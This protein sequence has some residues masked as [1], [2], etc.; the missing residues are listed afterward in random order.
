MQGRPLS[1][2]RGAGALL[3]VSLSLGVP[4]FSCKTRWGGLEWSKATGHDETI[5]QIMMMELTYQITSVFLALKTFFRGGHRPHYCKRP[6]AFPPR[7]LL[8]SPQSRPKAIAVSDFHSPAFSFI[9]QTPCVP[10]QNRNL[11][12]LKPGDALSLSWEGFPHSPLLK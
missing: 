9:T 7:K 11:P 5:S 12:D 6:R 4:V 8:S 2:S 10:S 3:L 1:G